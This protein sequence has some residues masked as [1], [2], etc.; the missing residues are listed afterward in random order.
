M[1]KLMMK[2]LIVLVLA[3]AAPALAD[4][5]IAPAWRGEP[6]TTYSEW[7]Y[8]DPCNLYDGDWPENSSFVSHPEKEDPAI[9]WGPDPCDPT[10][11]SA[12]WWGYGDWGQPGQPWW[13]DTLPN[14]RQGGISM[15]AGSWDFYNFIHDQPAK[16][17]WVQITYL[18]QG[19][20]TADPVWFG[21]IYPNPIPYDP[22][23]CEPWGWWEGLMDPCDPC[24]FG[25][26]E[27]P[28]A[29]WDCPGDPME[30]WVG[31]CGGGVPE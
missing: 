13:V 29:E 2:K 31:G 5:L 23:N 28:L 30:T 26:C 21:A 15:G 24:S 9:E 6:G 14:G 19:G 16:D 4:D 12:Q 25:D 3:F 27:A 18:K 10:Y 7:T 17:I 22:C 11:F 8:D 20:G 1:K